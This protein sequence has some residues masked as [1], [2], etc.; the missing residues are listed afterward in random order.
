VDTTAR[1]LDK[2]ILIPTDGSPLSRKAAK[3]GVAAADVKFR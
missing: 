3:A 2:H 1:A